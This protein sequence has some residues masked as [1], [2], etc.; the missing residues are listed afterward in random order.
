MMFGAQRPQIAGPAPHAQPTSQAQQPRPQAELSK[1]EAILRI[2]ELY[3]KPHLEMAREFPVALTPAPAKGWVLL[4]APSGAGYIVRE[5][6]SFSRIEAEA[7][8]LGKINGKYADGDEPR[9]RPFNFRMEDWEAVT[10]DLD[11]P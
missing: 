8:L 7:S 6:G 5:D 4:I 1:Q 9:V 2:H 10:E 3:R 11:R